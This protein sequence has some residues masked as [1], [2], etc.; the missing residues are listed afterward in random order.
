M[1]GLSLDSQ[2]CE[3]FPY[4]WTHF[5]SV[6]GA[7]RG[8]NDIL[9]LCMTRVEVE[10]EMR[11]ICHSI[12]ASGS[13][14]QASFRHSRYALR[15]TFANEVYFRVCHGSINR[16]GRACILCSA[17][18]ISIVHCHFQA[19]FSS[20][21]A[22]KGSFVAAVPDVHGEV[23]AMKRVIWLWLWLWLEP[24]EHFTL[25]CQGHHI[26]ESLAEDVTCPR[27]EAKHQLVRHEHL[28]I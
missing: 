18:A 7:R 20:R 2:I 1:L 25:H 28:F 5:E 21:K 16:L 11:V 26:K 14:L 13:V 3:D 23:I 17:D 27:S 15:E 22:V 6:A 10:E 9:P 19:F 12:H 24:E 4:H 8:Y